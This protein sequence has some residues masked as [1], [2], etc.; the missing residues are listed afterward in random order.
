MQMP[1]LFAALRRTP[2][3]LLLLISAC[4]SGRDQPAVAADTATVPLAT[5]PAPADTT[6]A[7]REFLHEMLDRHAALVALAHEGAEKGSTPVRADAKELDQ[8]VDREVDQ[9]H[10]V[11]RNEF[12]ETYEPTIRP[13]DQA[14]IQQLEQA[15]S[16]D[17]ANTFAADTRAIEAESVRFVDSYLP[18]LQRPDVKTLA[19]QIRSGL[20]ASAKT[21]P[22]ENGAG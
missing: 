6:G 17:F 22:S 2:P 9:L 12:G 21:A 19:G 15:G 1:T 16:S 11:L 8:R 13:A 7:D 3:A 4:S 20:G 10:A 14:R 18:R 5:T